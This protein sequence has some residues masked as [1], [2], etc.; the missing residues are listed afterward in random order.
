[1]RETQDD[2]IPYLVVWIILGSLLLWRSWNGRYRTVGLVIGYCFQL[3]LYYWLPAV[4]HCLPWSQ[5]SGRDTTF[6]GLQQSTYGLAALYG[7]N[8]IAGPLFARGR[9]PHKTRI[10]APDPRMPGAYILAGLF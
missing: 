7:G 8:L 9:A 10:F 1:M 2:F 3:W 4:L 6:L 5:L